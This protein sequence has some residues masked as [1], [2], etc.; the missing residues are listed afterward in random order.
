MSISRIKKEAVKNFFLIK[1]TILE[2]VRTFY[3]QNPDEF[4][5]S[6]KELIKENDS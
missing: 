4:D 5:G 6:E 2:K 1:R 3:Q